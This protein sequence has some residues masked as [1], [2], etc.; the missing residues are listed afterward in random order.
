MSFV[1]VYIRLLQQLR[2]DVGLRCRTTTA[3]YKLNNN[4][5]PCSVVA[6]VEHKNKVSDVE[7]D[8]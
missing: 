5:L 7:S 4:K 8:N 6:D 2:R 3:I 1:D